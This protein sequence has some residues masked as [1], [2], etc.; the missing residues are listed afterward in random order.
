MYLPNRSWFET[1][2]AKR[3]IVRFVLLLTAAFVWPPTAAAVDAPVEPQTENPEFTLDTWTNRYDRYW[4]E[5]WDGGDNRYRLK[6]GSNNV[7]EWNLEEDLKLAADLIPGRFRFRFYHSRLYLD[8]ADQ[9]GRDTFELEL[10]LAGSGYLSFFASPTFTKAENSLG[11]MLQHRKQVD[12]YARLIVEFPHAVR[13]FAERHGDRPGATYEVFADSPVRLVLDARGRLSPRVWAHVVFDYVPPFE[14]VLED[15]DTGAVLERESGRAYSV[16]GWIEYAGGERGLEQ[17]AAGV[18]FSLESRE[19]NGWEMMWPEP[20]SAATP[21][22]RGEVPAPDRVPV[23]VGDEFYKLTVTDGVRSWRDDRVFVE[24]FVWV[25]LSG[26]WVLKTSVRLD[27]RELDYAYAAGTGSEIINR[28]VVVGA[29][30]QV[31]LGDTRRSVLESGV[32][33]EYRERQE[34]C[35]CGGTEPEQTDNYQDHRWYISYEYRFSPTRIIRLVETIDFDREDWG[36]FSI[37]DH[38][39]VQAVFSF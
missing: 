39:F 30:A 34:S 32:A 16:G 27:Y 38:G 8:S 33:M 20:V 19:K 4:R 28:S 9:R 10:R 5:V 29:G 11:L 3:T 22:A 26:R 15:N 17:P 7:R 12:R 23:G 31:K 13:N 37:H 14:T 6:F 1:M 2:C 18:N 25:P 21:A 36:S 35:G 24:P